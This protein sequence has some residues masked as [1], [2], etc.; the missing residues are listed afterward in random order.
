[1]TTIDQARAAVQTRWIQQW[2]NTTPYVFENEAGKEPST[3]VPWVRVSFRNLGGTQHSLGGI[4]NRVWQR[5]ARVFIQVMAPA[6]KGMQGGA[7][8]AQQARAVFEGERLGELI[9]YEGN[10]R[11]TKPDGKWYVTLIEIRAQYYEKK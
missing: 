10:V 9:C 3:A 7:D 6:N 5:D 1:M 8:I 11:E 4:G 2:G